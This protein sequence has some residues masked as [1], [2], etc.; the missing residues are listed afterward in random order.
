MQ[1]CISNFTFTVVVIV[2]LSR[3]TKVARNR[4]ILTGVLLGWCTIT[5]ASGE[6]QEKGQCQQTGVDI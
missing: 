2:C 4:H 6:W 1:C 3:A 5:Q